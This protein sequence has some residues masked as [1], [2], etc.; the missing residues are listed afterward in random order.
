MLM[1]LQL[2]L[3]TR[4]SPNT[5]N[6][7]SLEN[8]PSPTIPFR[9]VSLQSNWKHLNMCIFLAFRIILSRDSSWY[10]LSPSSCCCCSSSSTSSSSSSCCSSVLLLS[11]TSL[12]CHCHQD[13]E[14]VK[15]PIGLSAK[16]MTLLEPALR[17][18]LFLPL[19]LPDRCR[20]EAED[21]S[22]ISW[23]QQV[24]HVLLFDLCSSILHPTP[25][26]TQHSSLKLQSFALRS[27]RS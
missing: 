6:D 25:S 27:A 23:C 17:L 19:T 21:L 1:Q 5:L 26:S 7:L 15:P 20:A 4:L 10:A 12:A 2:T 14:N 16:L 11:L 3:A 8:S 18:F 24:R 22:R 9:S 13:Q